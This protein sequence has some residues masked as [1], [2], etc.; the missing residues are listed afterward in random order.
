[1][2]LTSLQ[3]EMINYFFDYAYLIIVTRGFIN[4]N[5]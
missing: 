5:E 3:Q 4:E 1:M 2:S